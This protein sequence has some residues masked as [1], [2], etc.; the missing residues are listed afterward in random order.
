MNNKYKYI[1][2]RKL[3]YIM[4]INERN[5]TNIIEFTM[6]TFFFAIYKLKMKY[7]IN[8]QHIYLIKIFLKVNK[9]IF[10]IIKPVYL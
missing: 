5:K 9:I 1:Y 2:L 3:N 4:N 6:L 7:R 10:Y 8:I